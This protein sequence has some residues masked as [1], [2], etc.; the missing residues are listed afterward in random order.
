V[1]LHVRTNS[2]GQLDGKVSW[3]KKQRFWLVFES[4]WFESRS[5]HQISRLR[6]LMTFHVPWP[7]PSTS[8][9]IHDSYNQ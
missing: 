5:G 1:K 3:L 2:A 6:F 9:A 8:F 7:L 4:T